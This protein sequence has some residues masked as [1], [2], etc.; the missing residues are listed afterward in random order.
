MQAAEHS[1]EAH[2]DWIAGITA[3]KGVVLEGRKVVFIAVAVHGGETGAD[4]REWPRRAWGRKQAAQ[5]H[6]DTLPFALLGQHV[7]HRAR[8]YSPQVSEATSGAG[9][10]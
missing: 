7:L 9:I 6:L 1:N 3:F 8:G 4:P 5:R 10:N 2:L